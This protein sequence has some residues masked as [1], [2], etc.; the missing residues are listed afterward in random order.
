MVQKS[1]KGSKSYANNRQKEVT[2]KVVS[3]LLPFASQYFCLVDNDKNAKSARS[4]A[5]LLPFANFAITPF[6][7]IYGVT[8]YYQTTAHWTSQWTQH[9]TKDHSR[10]LSVVCLFPRYIL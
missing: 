2:T 7:A 10:I 6:S 9:K 8:S 4:H 3:E 1:A 5:E